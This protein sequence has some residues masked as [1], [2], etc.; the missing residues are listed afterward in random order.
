VF[1]YNC[2]MRRCV[3][4]LPIAALASLVASCGNVSDTVQGGEPLFPK[5]VDCSPDAGP[6]S[7]WSHLYACYFGPTAS[8]AGCAGSSE[9]HGNADGSGAVMSGFVCGLTQQSCFQGITTSLDPM[10]HIP[11][12]DPTA[13]T[14][15]P[16]RQALYKANTTPGGISANNMPTTTANGPPVVNANW[17]GFTPADIACIQGWVSAGAKN[18]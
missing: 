17:A 10:A 13:K 11:L 15:I 1:G 18:D 12:V 16:L 7:T 5:P 4:V 8:N 2:G 9:C 6:C 14:A 3:A